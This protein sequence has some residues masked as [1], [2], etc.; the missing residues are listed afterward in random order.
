MAAAPFD[1][2]AR[3]LERARQA[4]IDIGS[5]SVRLVIYDGPRRAPFPICNEKAL[6]GLGRD[7]GGT[8]ALERGAVESA[9][10]TLARFAT[11]IREHGSP[12]TFVVATA[13]V[14]EAKDGAAFVERVRSLGL[15]IDVIEGREE[16]NLAAYG[17]ASFEPRATGL[18]GDMGGGSLELVAIDGG[19]PGDAAS[20]SIGPLRLMQETK[21]DLKA[22]A[23]DI[24]KAL[25]RLRWLKPSRFETLHAVGGAWRAI[26]RIHMQ[27]RNHP[28]PILHHYE[29][30][31]RQATET[32]DLLAK[33]SRSSLEVIP[34]VSSKR[35]DAL[36]Y[37]A[38]VM[39]AVIS[40]GKIAQVA[41]SA[42]GVREGV[43]YRALTADERAVDPLLAGAAYL[44][45][46]MAPDDAAGPVYCRFIEPAFEGEAPAQR[47]IRTAAALLS[48]VGAYFHPDL[49]GVQAFDSAL[50]APFYA[51]THQQHAAI[52]LA[53]YC[54]HEGARLP[55]DPVVAMLTEVELKHAQLV[56]AALR[57]AAT[58]APKAPRAI[59]RCSLKVGRDG[60]AFVVPPD[61]RPLVDDAVR[62]RFEALATLLGKTPTIA[63]SNH[64]E[65]W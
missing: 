21:G 49:R 47:R 33:Q 17:V 61:L 53:L 60:V 42:G 11:L 19:E 48:D 15:A 9:M 45:G 7:L 40:S 37:A 62:K 52:A 5:N 20:L 6:C 59:G 35:I 55:A 29:F 39:R 30:S 43:L 64:D 38:L 13:A 2:P 41:V 24:D 46:R 28:L 63:F 56:G 34:G 26:A 4:V 51:V 8:G 65:D 32:C 57:F 22:A 12:Q 3:A 27:L 31:A 54:R 18:V 50:R 44:A 23:R 1:P 58:F 10:E 36:P 16:A 25:G 14:R